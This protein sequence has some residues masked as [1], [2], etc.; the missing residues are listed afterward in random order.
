MTVVCANELVVGS[1]THRLA[2]I[3]EA[4]CASSPR[5]IFAGHAGAGDAFPRARLRHERD[6]RS[7]Q[8]LAANEGR[9][10]FERTCA[11]CHGADGQGGEMGPGI[12]TR[13]PLQTDEELAHARSRRPPGEGHAGVSIR[14]RRA[15]RS[16]SRSF[17][18]SRRAAARRRHA[19]AS[20][21]PAAR[22]SRGSCSIARRTTCRCS[23][24]TARCTCCARTVRA[25]RRVTSQ[26]DWPTYH[27]AP[28]G[29]RYSPVDQINRATVERLAP[30]WMFTLLGRLPARGHADRR[31]RRH[32]RHRRER[33][34][35]ARCR[36]GP[37]HLALQAS[38]IERARRRRRVRHQS[39]RGGRGRPRLHGHRRCEVA[40]AEPVHGRTH[41]GNARWRIRARTTAP[42]RRRWSWASW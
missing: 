1:S 13:I 41:V 2:I 35:R 32:V 3:I 10:A 19:S 38:T 26:V 25:Y 28:H 20:T 23:P 27:G 31:R 9:A 39:R 21:P 22:R 34:L 18:R 6:S 17:A 36:L 16:W 24:T 37:T 8:A 15:S 14:R 40:R 12:T 5:D 4:R 30:A 11:R 33:V 42:R 7:E 29:N